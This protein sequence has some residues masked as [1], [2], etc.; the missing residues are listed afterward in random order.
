MCYPRARL[1]PLI[2]GLVALTMIAS[3]PHAV[4][5]EKITY[6]YQVDP[7][8]EAMLW[9]IKNGKVTS[10]LIEIEASPIA[11]PALI[12]ATPTKRYD[13]VQSDVIG[14]PRSAERGLELRILSTAIRYR[15]EGDAHIVFAAKDSTISSVDELKGKKIGVTSLGSTGF[16]NLRFALAEAFGANVDITGGDFQWVELPPATMFAALSQNRVDAASLSLT[17]TYRAKVSGEFKPVVY[18][19]RKMFELFKL[20]MISSVNVGYPEKLD[21]KP[22]LYREF[23]R[24]LKESAAYMR[25]NSAAIYA[26]VGKQFNIEPDIFR[27]LQ[28]TLAEFPAVLERK[29]IA[30]LTKEWEL[31]HKYKLL[32]SVPKVEDFVWKGVEV[33]D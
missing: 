30:A 5:K 17:H 22:E 4:A 6:A 7:I 33:Q 13:V 3:P 23:N 24:M 19:G 31:A 28:A 20:Q 16:H 32:K 1:L 2:A 14:V 11:I 27:G 10:D 15:P 21:A 26:E 25:A 8:F 18:A 29:D 9:A 12:Q